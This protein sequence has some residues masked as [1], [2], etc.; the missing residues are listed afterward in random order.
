[1]EYRVALPLVN[2]SVIPDLLKSVSP[3]CQWLLS[4]LFSFIRAKLRSKPTGEQVGQPDWP[5]NVTLAATVTEGKEEFCEEISSEVLCKH[6]VDLWSLHH[7]RDSPH[8][9]LLSGRDQQLTEID[10]LS[11][12]LHGV[13]RGGLGDPVHP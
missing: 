9:S 7:P 13:P 10:S 6:A 4:S 1:M 12:D 3:Q 8:Y 2:D 5:L 11:S